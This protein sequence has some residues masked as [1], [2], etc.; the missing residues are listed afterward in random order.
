MDEWILNEWEEDLKEKLNHFHKFASV[1]VEN[2]V[3]FHLKSLRKG[4]V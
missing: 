4:N 1:I 3:C 2:K